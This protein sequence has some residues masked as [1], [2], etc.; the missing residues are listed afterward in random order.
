MDSA[1]A[2]ALKAERARVLNQVRAIT[3]LAQSRG[4]DVTAPEQARATAL[5]DRV[6][7]IDAALKQS[8]GVSAAARQPTE[9]QG[10]FGGSEMDG[11]T[12]DLEALDARTLRRD[13]GD[14][15]ERRAR[16]RAGLSAS[17]AIGYDLGDVLRSKVRGPANDREQRAMA[18]SS[19]VT[20][21]F[22]LPE[23]VSATVIDRL[24]PLNTLL[25]AGAGEIDLTDWHSS[26]ARIASDAGAFPHAENVE[27]PQS[28]LTLQ[29][30]KLVP[31]SIVA[32]VS[33]V[34]MEM[35][36]S[37][38]NVGDIVSTNLAK[39]FAQEI[40]R[41]GLFGAGNLEML[42]LTATPAITK[43]PVGGA[44]GGPLSVYDTFLDAR[45]ALL[46]ANAPAPTS[47]I[48]SVREDQVRSK[49]KDNEG[50]TLVIPSALEGVSFLPTTKM[51]ITQKVGTSTNCGS[52]LL[53]GFGFVKVGYFLRLRL[54]V[55]HERFAT[56]GAI[57]IIG[58][59]MADLLVI[60]PAGLCLVT[61]ITG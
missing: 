34:S 20:G 11:D 19:D 52:M 44:N 59:M 17:E 27:V 24:R 8:T 16:A 14:S 46:N 49:A 28:N 31:R 38:A 13:A 48:L 3:G 51:P 39:A 4:R 9:G 50:R 45:A 2:T 21:G 33:P 5:L 41:Q 15:F 12:L 53:G 61:G 22:L 47:A 40:D 6:D 55:L 1:Q 23:V 56:Q 10:A 60:Q 29:L 7:E 36:L 30:V 32:N 37:A 35:L 42:G 58:Y 25:A 18:A 57:G 54:Q 43:L 26:Y